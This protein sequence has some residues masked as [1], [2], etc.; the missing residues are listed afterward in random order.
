MSRDEREALFLLY[1]MLPLKSRPAMIGSA[2]GRIG[3]SDCMFTRIWVTLIFM[4]GRAIQESFR[5]PVAA[6]KYSGMKRGIGGSR[7]SQSPSRII[8][9][10]KITCLTKKG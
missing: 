5:G 9:Y 4:V 1:I 2:R 8:N 3:P 7:G 10:G 6:R